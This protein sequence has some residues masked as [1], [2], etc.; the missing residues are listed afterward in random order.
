[1]EKERRLVTVLFSDLVGSTVL[2]EML[3]A[4][5]VDELVS[6]AQTA[7]TGVV[8]QYGG[9]VA[10]YLGD[11][12]MALFG[13][14]V[15][16]EDDAERAVL[17]GLQMIQTLET[18]NDARPA[19]LPALHMRIGITTG[20]VIG[21]DTLRGY[22]VTGDAANTAARLQSAADVGGV[23]VSAETMQLAR[24]RI[25]F[26]EQRE[27]SLKGKADLVKAFPA[28][29]PHERLMERWE[30]RGT[31]VPL[32]GRDDELAALGSAWTAALQG[33]GCMVTITAEPG[34][35]KSRL[36][37]EFVE[38]VTAVKG[39]RILR[40]RCLSYS[41][42]LNLWLVADLVRSAFNIQEHDQSDRVQAQ[43]AAHVALR[44][45]GEEE[46]DRAIATDVLG[47]VFGL[48]RTASSISGADPQI[49]RQALV[50]TLRLLLRSTCALGPLLMILEDLH[51]LDAA[52]RDVLT[53]VLESI[54]ELPVLVVSTRRN[55]GT[56]PWATQSLVKHMT[57]HP[58]GGESA[59]QLATTV[60][61]AQL[62]PELERHVLERSGG[63]PFFLEELLRALQEA[64]ELEESDGRVS[65]VEGAAGRLPSTLTE[66]LLARLDRLDRDARSIAQMGSVI[67]RAFLD[68]LL[69][70]VAERDVST[71]PTPLQALHDA[72]L[73][74]SPV[75]S[76]G[77]HAFR[78]ATVR[79]VA[80]NT[81]L[82]RRRQ[83]L[84]AAVARGALQIYPPD[85]YVDVIAH[86]FALSPEHA[87]AARWLERSADRAAAIYANAAAIEQYEETR[88]R[89]ELI[90][91]PAAHRAR[92]DE[93][94]GHI[95]RTVAQYDE[96][97][98]ALE[99]AAEGYRHIGDLEAERST[100]AEIGRAQRSRGTPD[101]GID[102][103]TALLDGQAED[104]PTSGVAALHV[105]LARLYYSVGKYAEQ[106]QAA[107]KGSELASAA[108][109]RRVLAEAEMSRG[110]ALMQMGEA[111]HALRVFEVAIPVAEE[112]GHF[113]AL[114]IL[115]GNTAEIH[116]EAGEF[117]LSR[118]YRE[119]SAE[120]AERMGDPANHAFALVT[121]GQLA[122]LL[123]DWDSTRTYLEQAQR[124]S[125][126][127]GTS[128]YS[129]YLHIVLGQLATAQGDLE[130]ASAQFG[131][132]L[133][134]AGEGGD[135]QGARLAAFGLA[136]IDLL[137]ARPRE[138]LHHFDGVVD[139][140]ALDEHDITLRGALPPI[141]WALLECGDAERAASLA[142]VAIKRAVDEHSIL[143]LIE[144]Q[145][146]AGMAAARLG[147]WDDAGS[148]L[149][150]ILG[151]AREVRYPYAEARILYEYARMLA[152]RGDL[153][154]S[155]KE[156]REALVIFQ[157]LGARLYVRMA[158][159][160]LIAAQ[161]A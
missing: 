59:T 6:A 121:A 111:E 140:S 158:N 80:Y 54:R 117:Q 138:A 71:L 129:S 76:G 47:E 123:G 132:A 153:H 33:E 83:G 15:A 27:L 98:E 114:N 29:E 113:E 74:L 44:L 103:I 24:R 127:L 37:A 155:T 137:Q 26:G 92:V 104:V 13:A 149:Q 90:G 82:N 72:D 128:W 124:V 110:T 46:D 152:A 73:V 30:A 40:G 91:A 79:E 81:L 19:E 108:N 160:E 126:S 88:K 148:T 135:P 116:R 21:G 52:S 48:P 62:A 154:E 14:P 99:R 106:L 9:H 161:S 42:H 70:L 156:M 139:L 10:K 56:D 93:K 87:E 36:L 105:V 150:Q 115:L 1:V 18:V 145:R 78:H 68:R 85:E 43:V 17:A 136:E 16:R 57:L 12:M 20:E 146:V 89:Q 102:R 60:L 131:E 63:N 34:V 97:L 61:G 23:L 5:E 4:E 112:V 119:K 35:G 122:L 151:L 53:G 58:L 109:D 31:I 86:H 11:G 101:A 84:H 141:A 94:L 77:E 134:L 69:A 32:I 130:D 118:R 133:R 143:D 41:E 147:R 96:A 25:R 45:E 64:G 38:R 125:G 8:E 39:A 51:W 95:L 107:E 50:H 66:V 75:K 67:G 120:V 65:L 55:E 100:V 144:A 7:L 2:G 22:D 28:V 159:A 3:D 157:G 142:Q 49:R